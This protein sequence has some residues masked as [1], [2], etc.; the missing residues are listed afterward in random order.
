MKDLLNNLNKKQLEAVKHQSGP[1]LIVAGAG[2]GKTTVLINK[3]AY[4]VIEKKMKASSIL[5]LTFTEKAAGELEER[6]DS[7]LPYGC[8][9]VWIS[10]FHSFAERILRDYG[11]EIGINTSF[12]LLNQTDQWLLIR[13]NLD[14][15]KLDYYKPLGNPTK[16]I[17]ELIKHFSRL[18]DENI[19]V[20]EYLEYAKKIEKASEDEVEKDEAKR[21]TELASAYQTYNELL[22]DGAYLDF[23][24]LIVYLLRLFKERP[25]VLNFFRKQFK[26]VMVDEFQDTNLAQYELVKML[27]LP[28]NNL[29]VVGDDNQSIYKFRGASLSNILQFKDDYPDAK[30]IILNEN[31]RSCQE[32]LDRA[33]SFIKNNDPNTLEHKLGIS[34]ELKA[35]HPEYKDIKSGDKVNFYNF[36][37]QED[38]ISFVVDKIKEIT[39]SDKKSSY[40]DFAILVRANDTALPFVKELNRNNIPNQFMSWRGLYFKPVILDCLA[41]LRVLN[42][43]YD[44]VSLFRLLSMDV[45]YVSQQDIIIINK[46]ANKKSWSMF[47]A[48]GKINQISG[49][50]EDSV[51][52][53]N[54]LIDLIAVHS[55]QVSKSET[56]R[57]F[58]RFAYESG[59]LKNLDHER[60]LEI[61]SF[62]NQFYQKIKKLEEAEP[63]LKLKD[64][65][66]IIDMELEAGESGSLKVEMP[67]NDCVKIMTVHSAKGLEFKHVFIVNL[68]DKKFPTINRSEKIIIPDA[69][70]KEKAISDGD[71]HLEEERRLF[72]VAITRAKEN[73]FLTAAKDYGGAREK[74]PSRF[75]EELKLLS[76]IEPEISLSEKNEF[77]KDLHYLN[78]KT[79]SSDEKTKSEDYPLPSRF[80]FSQL[81]AFSVCPLQYKY[82]FILKVPADSDKSSL[83]FGRVLHNTLYNFLLPALSGG[84][85]QAKMFENKVSEDK[86]KKL[87]SKERLLEIYEEFWQD[88]GYRSKKDRED[89]KKRGRKSLELFLE[90]YAKNKPEEVLLLEKNFSFRIANDIIRGAIDRVDR[91]SDGTLEIIDY[92]TGKVK[93]KLDYKDKRQLILYQLF[94]EEFL[95]IKVSLLSYYYLEGG[96]KIS[97]SATE[98]D[99]TKLRTQ[100]ADEI[101]AI[102][103][104]EFPPKPSMMCSYCDFN[105][106]CEHR[107]L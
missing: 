78:S 100:I 70:I 68:V 107:Q 45:F 86:L 58:L 4:S 105:S 29:V 26:Q 76:I 44:S 34:K 101:K 82:A 51:K 2:T 67:D 30:E 94:L 63:D 38:E 1:L 74:K 25:F 96:K 40:A 48:L 90:D 18:K 98:K 36:L 33:Y 32:I 35:S 24:D 7:I 49:V 11:L 95:G 13:N 62:L 3:L 21:V 97:F 53:I 31:Y 69:L 46:E 102:K 91:L 80:S 10:T 52:N 72:Y 14:K 104:R 42:N 87:F 22:L 88:D 20:L 103:K 59:F 61:F 64:F 99:I 9:D 43:Y 77:L 19:S 65:I 57:I 47:E 56:S 73:L 27:A 81:A 79:A 55:Q 75:I 71:F 28:E 92:K 54:K 17:S 60:D 16:F 85:S 106:I 37:D 89:Y 23:G 8:T 83:I 5:L 15:F 12:K 39:K 50:S 84:M 66:S 6:A 93:E 41:Y